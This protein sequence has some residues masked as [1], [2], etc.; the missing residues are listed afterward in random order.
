MKITERF[1]RL[2]LWNKLGVIGATC[3]ILAFLGW[4]LWPKGSGTSIEIDADQNSVVQAPVN[5]PGAVVQNMTDS[6]GGTQ[7]IADKVTFELSAKLERKLTLNAVYVN[8]LE[9]NRYV[10]LLRGRLKAPFPIPNLRVEAHGETVEEINFT[11]TG[12]YVLSDRGKHE[13]YVFATWQDAIGNLELRILSR[14]AGKIHI[15][16]AV[17]E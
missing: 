15:R 8:K 9:N 12:I 17:Q 11:G 3:S 14:Q 4:L 10:T 2:N 7:I 5:S 6:P 16:F 1:K 13:G